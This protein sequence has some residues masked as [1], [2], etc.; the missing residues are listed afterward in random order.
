MPQ[1]K[2]GT[3]HLETVGVF[4]EVDNEIE[5]QLLASRDGLRWQRTMQRQPFLAPH[6]KGHWDV[7]MVSMTSP[8]IEVGGELWFYHGGTSYHHDWWLGGA[9][10]GIDHPETIDP[11]GCSAQF[12][13]GLAT[14]RKDGYAGLY[15]NQYRKG[16]VITKL[17][18]SLGTQIEVNL[19]CAPAGSLRVE[20]TDRFDQ[21]A[22]PCSRDNCDPIGGDSVAHAVT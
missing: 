22:G 12:G 17:L 6:G 4:R 2:V 18:I 21:V 7:H 14:L 5:V 11:L 10:E 8:P 15:A 16:V 19:K 3:Q 1:F 13:L 20:V 9:R